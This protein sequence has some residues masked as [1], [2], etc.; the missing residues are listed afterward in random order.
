MPRT[1]ENRSHPPSE[2][3]ETQA[4]LRIFERIEAGGS[5][6]VF[7]DW[8]TLM[9]C[10]LNAPPRE[11]D[12]LKAIQPYLKPYADQERPLDH[13]CQAFA[14]LQIAMQK[15]NQDV[16]G[17]LYEQYA[18]GSKFR[19][20]AL[21]QFFTPIEVTEMMARMLI[22]NTDQPATVCDPCAGSGRMLVAAAKCLHPDSLF[23]GVDL[24]P[25]C[26]DMTALNLL[27]F[28]L[29]G[30]VLRGN[31]LSNEFDAGYQTRRT[32]LGGVLHRMST[33]EVEQAAQWVAAK[34]ASPEAAAS[35]DKPIQLALFA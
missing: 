9:L 10:T 15:T 30:V 35:V 26:A 1:P 24:D 5:R 4:I 33:S 21:G 13:L 23:V 6:N 7:P 34:L 8:L 27:F 29:N 19:Q 28:N 22:D 2:S 18:A 14:L 11:A 17:T 25:V 3:E 31:S 20:Q 32:G 16:L 12:Y